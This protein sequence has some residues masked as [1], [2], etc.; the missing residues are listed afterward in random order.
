MKNEIIEKLA[1]LEH[2][3]W[4]NW[5]KYLHRLCIKN[6]DGSLTIPKERVKHW[7]WEIETAYKD[8]PEKLKEYDRIEVKKQCKPLFNKIE[9]LEN[10]IL[11]LKQ[12]QCSKEL[13]GYCRKGLIDAQEYDFCRQ[14]ALD[15]EIRK[16]KKLQEEVEK[17]NEFLSQSTIE[18]IRIL[19]AKYWL[20]HTN[21]QVF[22]AWGFNYVPTEEYQEKARKII[23]ID[24]LNIFDS[25]NTK[26]LNNIDIKNILQGATKY[27]IGGS[28]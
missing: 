11:S 5:Q 20:T 18:Q 17:T 1:D 16:N 13:T 26:I 22:A 19:L 14:K 23:D 25:T 4:S 8:L 2:K 6:E 12:H 9:Q 3:R 28:I 21:D 27:D 15:D 10:Q 7:N 24:K